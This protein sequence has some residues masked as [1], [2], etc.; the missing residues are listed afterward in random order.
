MEINKKKIIIKSDVDNLMSK[1]SEC[2][3]KWGTS[4]S[5]IFT[6][7]QK[8]DTIKAKDINKLINWV[9]DVNTKSAA[10][11]QVPKHVLQG[12]IITDIINKMTVAAETIK[13]F[14]KCNCNH[15]NCNCNRCSCNQ[16]GCGDGNNA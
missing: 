12:E 2:R 15:C 3:A 14:C 16:K 9:N 10:G 6:P 11:V 7:V 5:E 8:I 13:N 4:T 1:I